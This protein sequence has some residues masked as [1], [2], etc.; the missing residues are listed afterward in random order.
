MKKNASQIIQKELR[1]KNNLSKA[2]ILQSFFKTG[3]G[4]YGE[5][6]I[7]WG[8]TVPETRKIAQKYAKIAS[9]PEI[10][11]LLNSKIHEQR[12][13]ALLILVEKF[14]KT[15]GKKQKE[16]FN[17]YLKNLHCANN[18]DL[19][20]LSADKILG[21]YIFNNTSQIKILRPLAI[22]NNLWHRRAAIISTFYFIKNNEFGLTLKIAKI[23]LQDK[24]D[25]IQKAV[26]WM[27]REI[28]KRS[29]KIE[30][31][32]LKKYAS[33]MP[34]TMLRYAIEKFPPKKRKAYLAINQK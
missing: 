14:Q 10:Q 7:F 33:K 21:A 5:G 12:L 24:H 34:R 2:K 13:C 27:L 25:L 19:I 26:G 22:S 16:V 15:N 31:K 32:F 29:I 4:Q 30:E 3:P 28:G 1:A 23:L 6:D 18:W 20:D 17:F 9:F 11:K 8:I